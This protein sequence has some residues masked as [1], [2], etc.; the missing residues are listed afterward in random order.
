MDLI[1]EGTNTSKTT[2]YWHEITFLRTSY[3]KNILIE[4]V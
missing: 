1:M 4:I 2:I 3:D